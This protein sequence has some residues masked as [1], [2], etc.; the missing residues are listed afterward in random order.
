MFSSNRRNPIDAL[1]LFRTCCLSVAAVIATPMQVVSCLGAVLLL[2][3]GSAANGPPRFPT[4]G[5]DPTK[6]ARCQVGG[7]AQNPLVT[8]W[9][10]SEK[11]RLESLLK[12]QP[13][14]VRYTGCEL[15]LVDECR[16]EGGYEWIRTTLSS[17][18]VEIR[19]EDELYA[20]LPLGA[21]R[22]QG[23]LSQSGRLMVRTR[24]AGQL[25]LA[26]TGV[27]VFPNSAACNSATHVI[28]AVSLGAFKL[29]RG[30]RDS[31]GGAVGIQS[32]GAGLGSERA[33]DVV[34][35]AGID[36]A[37]EQATAEAAH[38]NCASPLQLFLTPVNTTETQGPPRN[39][40]DSVHI[41]FPKQDEAAW[42]LYDGNGQALCELPCDRWVPS[43]SRYMLRHGEDSVRVPDDLAF[44][45][46]GR[47]V[48]SYHPQI[49]SPSGS[50]WLFWAAG[51]WAIAPGISMTA[52]GISEALQKPCDPVADPLC[53]DHHSTTAA[54][55]ITGGVVFL[56]LF[57][58]SL[59]YYVVSE[60]E[61]FTLKPPGA[62]AAEGL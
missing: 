2:S 52:I 18:T 26:G 32:V 29:M 12:S 53:D 61:E 4:E 49:G 58:A 30:S 55:M 57:A 47:A 50:T 59:Y 31:Y 22:L 13:V 37:C 14:F 11:A 39:A 8:E 62:A 35:E 41:T 45:P 19:S 60:K 27:P 21:A 20:K 33:E 3:C 44:E 56:G 15:R 6:L 42:M 51:A 54:F 40:P 10:A 17:D 1:V 5:H 34:H 48:A 23:E 36:G 28:S 38:P 7:G 43:K 25:R 16:I 9:V 24:V 46:G